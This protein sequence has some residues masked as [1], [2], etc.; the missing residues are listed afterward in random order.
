MDITF[1][2]D[3][4]G[5]LFVVANI[6]WHKRKI[7]SRISLCCGEWKCSGFCLRYIERSSDVSEEFFHTT[8]DVP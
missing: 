4:P 2:I 3:V 1:G 5:C 6:Y 8:G 7:V